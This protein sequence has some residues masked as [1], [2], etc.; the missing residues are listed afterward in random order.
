MPDYVHPASPTAIGLLKN[1]TEKI[2]AHTLFYDQKKQSKTTANN[3]HSFCRFCA[4]A[5]WWSPRRRSNETAPRSGTTRLHNV[6]NKCI[7]GQ[8]LN[9]R[10]ESWGRVLSPHDG[11]ARQQYSPRSLSAPAAADRAKEQVGQR[12]A[13]TAAAQPP[14]HSA[15]FENPLRFHVCCPLPMYLDCKFNQAE[16]AF[17]LV[18][19]DNITQQDRS[20]RWSGWMILKRG[21]K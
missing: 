19:K 10:N 13:G 14:R 2:G 8:S 16:T 12:S 11:S 5:I 15:A 20:C 9:H 18:L 1:L 17:Y 3:R 7:Y 21:K 4:S 6:V